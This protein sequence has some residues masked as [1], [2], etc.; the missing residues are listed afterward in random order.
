MQTRFYVSHES[1]QMGPYTIDEIVNFVGRGTLSPLDYIYDESLSDWIIFIDHKELSEK[2]KCLKPKAPPQAHNNQG[3]PGHG[4][5]E[6]AGHSK[7]TH[8]ATHEGHAVHPGN[9]AEPLRHEW[10]VLKG[11]NKFGPFAF[12]DMI[13][14]L[15]QGAIYEYDFA[16]YDGMQGWVRIA[17]L[18]DF[19][20]DVL[21][22]LKES[23]MPELREVFFRRRHKRALYGAT[24]IVHDN[25]KVWKGTGVEISE[26]GAG[27]IMENATLLP[28]QELYL[29]FK[30]GDG[31]P[32][33]NA[34][35]EIVSKQYMNEL[36]DP[37]APIKYGLKFKNINAE[38]Q[39]LLKDFANK[40]A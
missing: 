28:G 30:P 24:I 18:S 4:Q 2:V 17:E 9:I 36:N 8:G 31:V 16:W 32:P 7:Q 1:Q 29:H 26:G 6:H 33:F 23:S 14:M 39:K 25:K 20:K 5:K 37:N 27:V 3:T 13:K 35:C 40:A 10:F 22:K 15:Q 12:P 21:Q 11:E 34:V 19:S 38:T